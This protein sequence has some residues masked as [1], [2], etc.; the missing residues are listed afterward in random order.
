MANTS[1]VTVDGTD[2]VSS[3]KSA[4]RIAILF[5]F[6]ALAGLALASACGGGMMGNDMHGQMRGRGSQVPQTPVISGAPQV[7]V[8]IINFDFFPRDLTVQR[9]STVTWANGDAVPHDATDVAG[10]WSTGTLALGE[11]ATLTFDSP[12]AYQYL[13]TIH[14]TMKATLNVV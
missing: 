2:P 10:N 7:T 8:E 4:L 11:S 14:P 1:W 6:A 3:P 13:C 9:G 5:I 12:G